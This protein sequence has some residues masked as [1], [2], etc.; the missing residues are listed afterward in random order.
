[1]SIQIQDHLI[2]SVGRRHRFVWSIEVCKLK[3]LNMSTYGVEIGP[4]SFSHINIRVVEWDCV[5]G[6]PSNFICSEKPSLISNLNGQLIFLFYFS[7][8]KFEGSLSY[9]NLQENLLM[10]WEEI[11]RE[12]AGV[13]EVYQLWWKNSLL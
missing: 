4:V 7:N 5:P 9:W 11:Q 6:Y 3:V 8:L 10:F 13:Q 1:M 12:K 2:P